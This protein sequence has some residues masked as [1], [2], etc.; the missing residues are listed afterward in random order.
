MTAYSWRKLSCKA[1]E[2]RLDIVLSAGQSFRWRETRPGEW[3]NVLGGEVV[4]M[5][6]DS[7]EILYRVHG[8][9]DQSV[10]KGSVSALTDSKTAC[11]YE[12]VL[13]DYF[14]LDVDV[15]SLHDEWSKVD[16]NFAKVAK[17]FRGVRTLRL[18]P[19][20]TLFAFICS[21]NNNIPRISSMVEKLCQKYGEDLLEVDG[22]R[23]FSFPT[24]KALAGTGVEEQLRSLGFGYRA[25][26]VNQSAKY[27]LENHD[28]KWLVHLRDTPYPEAHEGN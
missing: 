19:V 3:T 17:T 13:R 15:E 24:I 27:I 21:S 14:Q 23:Y 2:I 12:S 16:P 28:E 6:Q 25:K 9:P 7:K 18:D 26:F 20:E 11:D 22:V 10:K 5:K 4:T 8:T 1:S